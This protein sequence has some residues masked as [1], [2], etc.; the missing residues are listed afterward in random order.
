MTQT[1][2]C[3]TC[4]GGIWPGRQPA[5][6]PDEFHGERPW[7]RISPPVCDTCDKPAV[8]RHPWGGL[9]CEKCHKRLEKKT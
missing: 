3:P 2:F 4:G 9:H 6:C 7:V 5:Q 8:W 1:K